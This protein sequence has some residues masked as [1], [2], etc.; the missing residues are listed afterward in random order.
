MLNPTGPA[1][2]WGGAGVSDHPE[3]DGGPARLPGAAASP[4][5]S[6]G[7]GEDEPRVPLFYAVRAEKAGSCR[8]GPVPAVSAETGPH[9]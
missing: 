2:P 8:Q 9:A 5:S 4:S 1:I 3:W 7:R 6:P